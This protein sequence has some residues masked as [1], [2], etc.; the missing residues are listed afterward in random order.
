MGLVTGAY[1]RTP[2]THSQ[3]VVGPGLR[4]QK[5][6][7]RDWESALPRTPLAQAKGAPPGRP[8]AAPAARK[9]SSQ[10]RF[11]GLMT[12]PRAR[13]PHTLSQW[14]VGPG[15]TFQRTSGRGLRE[16]PTPDAPHK[17]KRRPPRVPSCRPNSA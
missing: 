16:C 11:L 14:V 15:S 6:S 13:S 12:G 17:G 7:G 3:W 5:M 9:A 8:R 2:R 4:P 10:E 1:A